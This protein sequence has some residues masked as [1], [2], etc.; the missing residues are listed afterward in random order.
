MKFNTILYSIKSP[1]NVGAITRSH[2]A[3]GGSKL[4]FVGYEKPWDFKKGSQAFSR[5]LEWQCEILFFQHFSEFIKWSQ[6]ENL[7]NIAIEIDKNS[8]TPAECNFSQD[9]NIIIGNESMGLPDE[10]V[11]QCDQV[12]TIPQIG[13]VGSLN[14]ATSASL[15]MYE[16]IR[17]TPIDT[18]K[19]RGRKY[20]EK[21]KE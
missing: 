11:N 15:I 13:S 10:V 6:K 4:I 8:M 12:I 18:L 14:V 2:V 9:C 21:R 20:F 17:K 16:I 5:K 19:L 1:V 3:F 7:I